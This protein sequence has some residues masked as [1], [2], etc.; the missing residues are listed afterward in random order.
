MN[1]SI[2]YRSIDVDGLSIF[3]REAGSPDAP[4]LQ[5]LHGLSSSS[6]MY[7][8]LLE[9]L[10]D[11]FHLIAPDYPGFGHSEWP[12]PDLFE[13][14]FDS[15]ATVMNRF[16]EAIGLPRF[17]LFM[18]DYGGSVGFRMA[19]AYP[20]KIEG[21]IVQ[22]AVVHEEGLGPLWETR[23]AFWRNRTAHE[24][25]LQKNL[26]SLEAARTRHLG[27]DPNLDLYNP[28]L[29][30][31]EFHFLNSPNQQRIQS[32]LFFNYRTN[33]EEYPKWQQWLRQTQPRLLVLWGKYDPS[34]G[35]SEPDRFLNEVPSAKIHILEAGHFALDTKAEEIATAVRSFL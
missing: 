32:D 27:S 6:R 21:L 25:E 28:D 17:T 15:I 10:A 11:Q 5:L 2:S 1:R 24:A 7:Q 31:D 35:I 29:W 9:R 13:Y 34:F 33:L 18:Q 8:S 14:T 4:A 30:W 20:E 16:A 12:A 22:N 3:Y 23:R 19:L 26:L